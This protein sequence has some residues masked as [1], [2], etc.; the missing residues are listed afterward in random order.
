MV[1]FLF[2]NPA[3]MSS[4]AS[5]FKS[6][7]LLGNLSLRTLV[8]CIQ[9]LYIIPTRWRSSD[10]T[11]D[12]LKK[13]LWRKEVKATLTA[14]TCQSSTVGPNGV[15][16]LGGGGLVWPDSLLLGE[17]AVPRRAIRARRQADSESSPSLRSPAT[18][19]FHRP[20]GP[21]CESLRPAC[22]T[23]CQRSL[24]VRPAPLHRVLR[25]W[26]SSSAAQQSNFL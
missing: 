7:T 24:Q 12:H 20:P 14:S 21:L 6:T 9:N 1:P 8:G 22:I 17:R 18:Q 5:F 16:G 11:G 26:G 25:S 15:A 19:A 4:C 13:P 2:L 23:R 3:E 10:T